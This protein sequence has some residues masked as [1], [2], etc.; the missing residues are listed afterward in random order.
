M[1]MIVTK[2]LLSFS[3]I[4]TLYIIVIIIAAIGMVFISIIIAMFVRYV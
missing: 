3:G 4:S 2:C 1:Y